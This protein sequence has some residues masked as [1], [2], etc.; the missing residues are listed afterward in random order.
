MLIP[1]SILRLRLS[2]S[3]S[4]FVHGGASLQEVVIPVLLINK[5]RTSDVEQVEVEPILGATRLITTG[6]HPVR[7]YQTLPV[8]EKR[9]PIK[10]RI[11]LYAQDGTALSKPEERE[12]A[13]VSENPRERETSIRLVLSTAADAYNDKDVRLVLTRIGDGPERP[14]RTETFRLKRSIS[15]DF[16]L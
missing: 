10:L 11:G 16:D 13:E 8:T 15:G 3:G 5:R 14:Y 7:L 6:Q 12:F 1:R 4:R 9:R 2:G